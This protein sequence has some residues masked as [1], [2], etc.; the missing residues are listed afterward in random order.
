[1]RFVEEDVYESDAGDELVLR[2]PHPG[3][4]PMIRVE[5]QG[6]GVVDFVLV[7]HE[8]IKNAP[9]TMEKT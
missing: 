5:I 1:V 6:R 9:G 7:R 3:W 2:S 4:Y 8:T